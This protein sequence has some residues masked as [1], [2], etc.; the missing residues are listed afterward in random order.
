[1]GSVR[2]WRRDNKAELTFLVS[3][4]RPDMALE[5]LS[6]VKTLSAAINVADIETSSV[7][8]G[9]DL[10]AKFGGHPATTT[11]FRKIGDGNWESGTRSGSTTVHCGV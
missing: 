1:M 6:A 7:L 8:V 11:F 9:A 10:W 2:G 4:D 5:M 3:V